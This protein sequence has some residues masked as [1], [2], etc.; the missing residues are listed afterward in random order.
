MNRVFLVLLILVLPGCVDFGL[1]KEAPQR[2]RYVLDAQR[3]A[4]SATPAGSAAKPNQEIVL[5][6]RSFHG[7]AAYID[8]DF[9][10]RRG[11][12]IEADYYN[13]FLTPPAVAIS[14][15]ARRWLGESDMFSVVQGV[16]TRLPPTHALEADI[17]ALFGD[18]S[19][20]SA[21]RAKIEIA[22]AMVRCDDPVM[23]VRRTYTESIAIDSMEPQALIEGWNQALA[24]I[25]TKLER[26][27]RVGL[28]EA[29]NS[30]H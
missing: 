19:E 5:E 24:A 4:G 8:N 14:E 12:L 3:P 25:F 9:I 1:A 2:L 26:D 21:P 27:M 18:F 7:A 11:A 23:F 29:L 30:K 20:P 15:L 28:A 10:Y 22:F 16:G 17:F 13:G 6:V